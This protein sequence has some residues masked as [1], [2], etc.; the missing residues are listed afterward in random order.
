MIQ[1]H[2]P[3]PHRISESSR[4]KGIKQRGSNRGDQTDMSQSDYQEILRKEYLEKILAGQ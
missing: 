1:P 4:T 3:F 2:P